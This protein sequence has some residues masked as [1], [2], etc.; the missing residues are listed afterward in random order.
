M[1]EWIRN[2]GKLQISEKESGS[3]IQS[4]AALVQVLA[5]LNIENL[6]ET[7]GLLDADTATL[8]EKPEELIN[9]LLCNSKI[10]WADPDCIG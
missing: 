7:N 5:A 9:H 3:Y 1:E 6:L 8:T 2:A 10:D 4:R